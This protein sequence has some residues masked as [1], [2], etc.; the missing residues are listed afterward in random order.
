M[1]QS[2]KKASYSPPNVTK[3]VLRKEQAV[4]SPCAVDISAPDDGGGGQ[5]YL[6]G[7]WQ[8]GCK[9]GTWSGTGNDGPT[10]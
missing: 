5:C 10:S 7:A 1:D 2:R 6:P 3:V 8:F 9:N 4:L